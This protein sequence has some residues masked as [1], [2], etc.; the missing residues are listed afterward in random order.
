M[1]D[2]HPSSKQ[3]DDGGGPVYLHDRP[4]PGFGHA[5]VSLSTALFPKKE[6][7]RMIVAVL[8][9]GLKVRW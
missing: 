5:E 2:F 9:S 4:E 7:R 6:N 1:Q 8:N 3:R